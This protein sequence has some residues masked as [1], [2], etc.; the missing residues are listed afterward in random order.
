MDLAEVIERIELG[1]LI[2]DASTRIVFANREAR[3]LL[4]V[5]EAP[6]LE[7]S[8]LDKR[9][10]VIHPDGT[11]FALDQLP[12]PTAIVERREVRGVLMGVFRPRYEDRV[13]LMVNA[14]PQLDPDG[15]VRN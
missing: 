13:W 9:W 5:D 12:V 7:S 1:V 14:L 6:L 2:Q 10:D 11:P 8:S 15:S 3:E 4:G